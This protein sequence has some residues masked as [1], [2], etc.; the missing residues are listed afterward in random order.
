MHHALK[1]LRSVEGLLL[2]EQPYIAGNRDASDVLTV[3][4]VRP[5]VN[6]FNPLQDT[7]TGPGTECPHYW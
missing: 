4:A 3:R 1:N 2:L 7:H 6:R 5:S